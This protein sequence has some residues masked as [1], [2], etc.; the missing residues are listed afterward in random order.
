MKTMNNTKAA[1]FKRRNS[2]TIVPYRRRLGRFYWL[3]AQQELNSVML[4]A[5]V[6]TSRAHLNRVLNNTPGRGHFTRRKLAGLAWTAP[7]PNAGTYVLTGEM[8]GEL[9]WDRSGKIMNYEG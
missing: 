9:G 7:H 3:L 6:G 1:I 4:A 5:L 8:L 2:W